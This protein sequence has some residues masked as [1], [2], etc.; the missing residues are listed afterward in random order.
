[1]VVRQYFTHLE[2]WSMVMLTCKSHSH[3]I[4]W[5]ENFCSACSHCWDWL[6]ERSS[7][8]RMHLQKDIHT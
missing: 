5:L 6:D 2:K 3:S 8:S 7:H 4:W 1:M